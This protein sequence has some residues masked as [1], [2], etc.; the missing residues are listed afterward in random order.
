VTELAT[1]Q[2]CAVYTEIYY[3]MNS[4]GRTLLAFY[5]RSSYSAPLSRRWTESHIS[6][7][8]CP[9]STDRSRV[10]HQRTATGS[11]RGIQLGVTRHFSSLPPCAA[12]IGSLHYVLLR[13]CVVT[14][15]NFY[16]HCPPSPVVKLCC[17][18]VVAPQS[19][20]ASA[21]ARWTVPSTK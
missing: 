21:A 18:R 17:S 20:N 5:C 16:S 12:S 13:W 4:G 9:F 6:A 11:G 2:H 10:P 14:V 7:A 1:A 15:L 8:T 19:T 3:S